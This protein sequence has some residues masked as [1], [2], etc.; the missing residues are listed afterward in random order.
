MLS[1]ILGKIETED[2]A[3]LDSAAKKIADYMDEALGGCQ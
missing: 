1:A 2:R 3:K